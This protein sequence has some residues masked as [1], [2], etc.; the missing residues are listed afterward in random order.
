MNWLVTL[1]GGAVSRVFTF[2][3]TYASFAI[4][5]RIAMATAFIIAS[6]ALFLSTA[7]AIKAVVMGARVSFPPILANAT[8]FIPDSINTLIAAIV[9]VRTAAAL[10]RWTQIN[11]AVY[12]DVPNRK[13]LM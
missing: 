7:V 6:A 10:Y 3:Y 4:A 1:L 12:A 11:L 13:L 8:F 9:T 5:T 2:V